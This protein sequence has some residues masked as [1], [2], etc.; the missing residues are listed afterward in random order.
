M[1]IKDWKNKELSSLLNERWGFS[2]DLNKLNESKKKTLGSLQ[3]QCTDFDKL[4][5]YISQSNSL[6]DLHVAIE[7]SK[8]GHSHS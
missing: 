3:K 5:S 4:K 2:M 7:N 8:K 6:D 1:S